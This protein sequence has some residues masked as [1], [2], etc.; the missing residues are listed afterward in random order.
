MSDFA[1]ADTEAAQ[2][3]RRLRCA[4]HDAIAV[5]HAFTG[6][7]QARRT[8]QPRHRQ[9][10]GKSPAQGPHN[11]AFDAVEPVLLVNEQATKAAILGQLERLCGLIKAR[12]LAPGAERDVL[13]VFL[14]GHGLRVQGEP[15]LYF[16]NFD[17]VPLQAELHGLSVQ[18][19]GEL[20]ATVPAEVVLIIDAC[21]AG[22]AG[23]QVVGG[24]DPHELAQ[25]IHAVSER[26]L[27]V[28]GAARA[29]EL[30]REDRTGGLGVFTEA[31]LLALRSATHLAPDGGTRSTRSI[32]MMGLIA[33]LQEELP[34]VTA[35]AGTRAQTP[36]CRIYGDLLPLTIYRE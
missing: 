8:G 34:R 11:L 35:R 6:L 5:H 13:V 21:H 4:H 23:H 31:L 1:V 10:R 7:G 2:G 12:G 16:F 29:E 9:G 25:R 17:M 33:G 27:Y 22:A 26:G 14:S 24:L 3:T 19:L 36:V 20:L 28:L 32:T 15:D 18:E 30:A